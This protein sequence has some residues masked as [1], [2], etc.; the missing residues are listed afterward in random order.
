MLIMKK[1]KKGALFD[2]LNEL[3]I[4]LCVG[5]LKVPNGPLSILILD[6]NY[7]YNLKQKIQLIN[8]RTKISLYLNKI[9]TNY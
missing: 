5:Q 4:E 3:V 6:I 1:L 9:L 2:Y 8:T 7:I